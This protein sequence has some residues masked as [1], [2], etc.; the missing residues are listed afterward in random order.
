MRVKPHM[1]TNEKHRKLA[2]G[3]FGRW[4]ARGPGCRPGTA[5]SVSRRPTRRRCRPDTADRLPAAGGGP[6]AWRYPPTTGGAWCR[7]GRPWASRAAPG[8]VS[9]AANRTSW[10]RRRSSTSAATSTES[11]R[12]LVE[13]TVGRLGE[14]HV[15]PPG[16][17]QTRQRATDGRAARRQAR[18]SAVE[19]PR[20]DAVASKAL[21]AARSRPRCGPTRG[22]GSGG[23]QFGPG[24]GNLL[25]R[26]PSGAHTPFGA[27]GV[28][29]VNPCDRKFRSIPSSDDRAGSAATQSAATRATSSHTSPTVA[30]APP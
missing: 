11:S 8:P 24:H 1:S 2:P 15:L 6:P 25:G 29:P 4:A 9:I 10:S 5:G 21:A 16:L 22:T 30:A 7:R 3:Q 14:L 17:T 27:P 12:P 26:A 19:P 13:Q 28:R 23:T 20:A 18:A